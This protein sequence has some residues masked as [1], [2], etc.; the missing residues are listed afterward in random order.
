[1]LEELYRQDIDEK[2]L[3][4]KL[5]LCIHIGIFSIIGVLLF[6]APIPTSEILEWE[7][8]NVLSTRILAVFMCSSSLIFLLVFKCKRAQDITGLLGVLIVIDGGLGFCSLLSVVEDKEYRTW[9]TLSLLSMCS[10]FCVS[11]IYFSSRYNHIQK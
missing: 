5:I 4:L 10:V 8:C 7:F 6:T 9:S 2:P 1:M 11:W 3:L